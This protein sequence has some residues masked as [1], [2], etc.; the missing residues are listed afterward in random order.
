MAI[1]DKD[2]VDGAV[3]ALGLKALQDRALFAL[4]L[5]DPRGAVMAQRDLVP[6]GIQD[7]VIARVEALVRSKTKPHEHYL[8]KWDRYHES[9]DWDDDWDLRPW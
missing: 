2:G 5:E 1:S 8:D 9:G 3:R 7:E 4:I 6:K